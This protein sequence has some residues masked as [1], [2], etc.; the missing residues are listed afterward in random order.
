MGPFNLKLGQ[1]WEGNRI[2]TGDPYPIKPA[3]TARDERDV[4]QSGRNANF[5]DEPDMGS[6]FKSDDKVLSINLK[7]TGFRNYFGQRN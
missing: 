3:L 2:A 7:N 4:A 5:D 1:Q 6:L